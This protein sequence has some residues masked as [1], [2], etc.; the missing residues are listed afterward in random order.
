M[1]YLIFVEEGVSS[2][3][4][5]KGCEIF[6]KALRHSKDELTTSLAECLKMIAE[7]GTSFIVAFAKVSD[8]VNFIF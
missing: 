2:F 7:E 3:Y 1:Y 5:N 6:I 8:N 4:E